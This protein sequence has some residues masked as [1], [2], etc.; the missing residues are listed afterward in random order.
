[1][2]SG[3]PVQKLLVLVIAALAVLIVITLVVGRVARRQTVQGLL[4]PTGGITKVY[5]PYTG[6]VL[7]KRVEEG[8]QVRAGDVLY[9]L[10]AARGS[11]SA[12]SV[13]DA[14]R[15]QLL[16]QRQRLRGQM[17]NEQAASGND[18]AQLQQRLGSLQAERLKLQAQ[19][20]SQTQRAAISARNLQSQ[21]KLAQT[22]YLAT[23]AF[24]ELESRHLALQAEGETLQRALLQLDRQILDAEAER[25]SL[26]LRGRNRVGD[27]AN[28]LAEVEQQLAELASRTALAI[29]APSAGRVTGLLLQVG[30]SANPQAPLATLLPEGQAL[31]ARLYAPSRAIGFIRPG[32]AVKLRLHA[33]PYVRFGSQQGRVAEVS[34]ALLLPSETANLPNDEAAY[35]VTVQ[36]AAQSLRAYGE[37]WPLQAGMTLEADVVMERQRLIAWIVEPL[38]ALRRG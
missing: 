36:L 8:Q 31:Q 34:R 25:Q 27:Y 18:A 32:Q 24:E 6:L 12:A 13:E 16:L 26:S 23:L 4:E 15:E 30:Q 19:A 21:K 29:R 5:A 2:A 22:G 1:M 3:G 37:D 28:D 38:L 9:V 35:P 17:D 11:L 10:S 33:F 20:A 7:E 14:V